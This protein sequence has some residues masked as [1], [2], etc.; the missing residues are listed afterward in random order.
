[1]SNDERLEKDPSD[2]K[3]LIKDKEKWMQIVQQIIQNPRIVP[4]AVASGLTLGG[5]ALALTF[6]EHSAASNTLQSALCLQPF[7]LGHV[8]TKAIF[9]WG[10]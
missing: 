8:A 2:L 6:G 7:Y 4:L 1:M 3:G 9:S 10:P 5:M